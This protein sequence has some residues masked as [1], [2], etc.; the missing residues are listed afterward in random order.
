MYTHFTTILIGI[1]CVACYSNYEIFKGFD[2]DTSDPETVDTTEVSLANENT[3]IT[4]TMY[5]NMT[6]STTSSKL[7]KK[8]KPKVTCPE[9]RP[10][11]IGSYEVPTEKDVVIFTKDLLL[12]M[13]E[14][15][16]TG[17]MALLV[18]I[19]ENT[20]CSLLE[21]KSDPMLL[22]KLL[23]QETAMLKFALPG[24]LRLLNSCSKLCLKSQVK[25]DSKK[26]LR[27]MTDQELVVKHFLTNKNYIELIKDSRRS[28]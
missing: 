10:T 28:V 17:A 22:V 8:I 9:E 13:F 12:S 7:R 20:I 24:F 23:A 25:P 16:E 6:I 11:N 1:T 27:R 19:K 14:A 4:E 26:P 15:Y 3:T 5:T 21:M 18:D 2:R